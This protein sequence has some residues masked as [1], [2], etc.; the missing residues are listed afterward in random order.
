M[1]GKTVK[2]YRDVNV[3]EVLSALAGIECIIVFKSKDV[4]RRLLEEHD[5]TDEMSSF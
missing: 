5:K 1:N 3:M 4:C 2:G